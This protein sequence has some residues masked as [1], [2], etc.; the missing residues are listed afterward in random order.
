M[1]PYS[2]VSKLGDSWAINDADGNEVAD[3]ETETLADAVL[4]VL[5][6][7][8]II[9]HLD[10]GLVHDVAID[11]RLMECLP[12]FVVDYD[13]DGLL[14]AEVTIAVDPDSERGQWK[15]R[16]RQECHPADACN[17]RSA[18]RMLVEQARR[19]WAAEEAQKRADGEDL[20]EEL[21]IDGEIAPLLG[22]L[23]ETQL[24]TIRINRQLSR[25]HLAW[26]EEH[27]PLA[28]K[29]LLEAGAK[30]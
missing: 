24:K 5:E 8:P 20:D 26:L 19:D 4:A 6:Q 14:A 27:R 28:Y 7:T 10:G 13:T 21:L 29:H 17:L 18:E 23:T 16:V 9:I 2:K 11:G 25:R 15:A 22:Q 30:A 3:V 1:G 12:I